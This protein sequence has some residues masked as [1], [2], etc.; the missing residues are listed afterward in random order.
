MRTKRSPRYV[1]LLLPALLQRR[2]GDSTLFGQGQ[3]TYL[4]THDSHKS[5]VEEPGLTDEMKAK[6]SL[7]L[8]LTSNRTPRVSPIPP[9]SNRDHAVPDIHPFRVRSHRKALADSSLLCEV[10]DL[11]G[12]TIGIEGRPRPVMPVP[13]ID[14]VCAFRVSGSK[15][16]ICTD[17][18]EDR[19]PVYSYTIQMWT[20]EGDVYELWVATATTRCV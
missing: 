9:S 17:H 5:P 4:P 13:R 16:I 2:I 8:S 12:T 3:H 18:E 11:P 10:C 7:S 19:R 6:H 14:S 1:L 15:P 20:L